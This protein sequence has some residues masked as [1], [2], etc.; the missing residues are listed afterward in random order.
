M[1]VFL[2]DLNMH[3][4]N[5]AQIDDKIDQLHVIDNYYNLTDMQLIAL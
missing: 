1:F 4:E 3:Y 5:D 2:I